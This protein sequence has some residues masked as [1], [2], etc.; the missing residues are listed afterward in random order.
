MSNDATSKQ[1][2]LRALRE[3]KQSRGGVESRH[4]V[5]KAAPTVP[6][7]IADSA[8]APANVAR[9][10][11][12]AGIASGPRKVKTGRPLEKDRPSSMAQLKPWI[13]EGMSRR[14]SYRR[15]VIPRGREAK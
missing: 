9:D 8:T 10:E 15:R 2:Q 1:D 12:T 3:A 14:T 4:A 7:R 6:T 11:G 5:R 13:A